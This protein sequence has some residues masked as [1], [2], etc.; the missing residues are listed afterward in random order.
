MQ[1]NLLHLSPT[2][3]YYIEV[4]KC[5]E[6]IEM[7]NDNVVSFLRY[8][9]NSYIS[10]VKE[11]EMDRGNWRILGL[12]TS[13]KEISF[14]PAPYL[15]RKIMNVVDRG[16]ALVFRDYTK[17]ED[18]FVFS[19]MESL[20]SLLSVHDKHWVNPIEKV[21]IPMEGFGHEKLREMC[22]QESHWQSFEDNLIKGSILFLTK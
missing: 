5:A 20:L 9:E 2:G 11:V 18:D 22:E 1:D 4:P 7:D 13:S 12:M 14:D 10:T 3:I 21:V 19:E 8:K 15:E 16:K 6:N 17:G